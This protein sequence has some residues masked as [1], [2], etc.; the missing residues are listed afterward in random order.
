MKK[1]IFAVLLGVT[2]VV[3]GVTAV[4]YMLPQNHVAS[5]EAVLAAAPEAVFGTISDVARYPEWRSGLTSVDV[6]ST[7]PVRWREHAGSDAITFE[8][9]ESRPPERLQVRIADPDLPF[10]GTWTYE[11]TRDGSST[12]LRITEHGEVYNP[13]FRFMSR[14][15]FGHSATLDAYLADLQARLSS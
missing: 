1:F 8:V 3:L 6:V 12:R 15:I 11:L 14:F 10:G 5:R 9:A 2:L 7:A 4:G 13:V